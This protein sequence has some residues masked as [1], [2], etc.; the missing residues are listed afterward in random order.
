MVDYY[1]MGQSG[2][3]HRGPYIGFKLAY[4]KDS[5]VPLQSNLCTNV[6]VKINYN[7]INNLLLIISISV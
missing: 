6:R 4:N 1:L 3:L 7:R 5:F 2:A